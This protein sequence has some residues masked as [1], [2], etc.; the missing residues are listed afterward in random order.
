MS[1]NRKT[2]DGYENLLMT[3]VGE[4]GIQGPAGPKGDKGDIG[5]KWYAGVELEEYS[6][7]IVESNDMKAG[8]YYLN[9]NS[10]NVLLIT[11]YHDSD[12]VGGNAFE[13]SVEKVG[14]IHGRNGSKIY[15]VNTLSD[16]GTLTDVK[17][18]D[19]LVT[20][21]TFNYYT[22]VVMTTPEGGTEV[23]WSKQGCLKPDAD[24]D[25]SNL[26]FYPNEF[27]EISRTASGGDL[28]LNFPV[29]PNTTYVFETGKSWTGV[30]PTGQSEIGHGPSTTEVEFTTGA[31]DTTASGRFY[32][33]HQI[34]DVN[35]E[36]ASFVKLY[37]KDG[38]SLEEYLQMI[39][40]SSGG[41]SAT[42]GLLSPDITE[43]LLTASNKHP[44]EIVLMGDS[45]TEG[46]SASGM[47]SAGSS[48]T[49]PTWANYGSWAGLLNKFIKQNYPNVTVRNVGYSG[50]TSSYGS[51]NVNTWITNNRQIAIVM[52][53]TNNR[54]SAANMNALANDYTTIKN[55]CDAV[56]ARMV[57]MCCI[58]A[59]PYNEAISGKYVATM[60]DVHTVLSNWALSNGYELVDLYAMMSRYVDFDLS[61][62]ETMGL[63][64]VGSNDNNLHLHPSDA[65]HAI[66]FEFIKY[67]LGLSAPSGGSSSSG[68]GSGTG[69]Y[70]HRL[71][72]FTMSGSTS[73]VNVT[74]YNNRSTPYN[75]SAITT[76]DEINTVRNDIIAAGYTGY[77]Q[78]GT[79]LCSGNIGSTQVC[80][81]YV[82]GGK[83]NFIGG[84][85][86]TVNFPVETGGTSSATQ[87][88]R[89]WDTVEPAGGSGGSSGGE[90]T[91]ISVDEYLDARSMNAIA[92]SPV[93][94]A[95]A[96]LDNDMISLEGRVK[97]LEKITENP[98]LVSTTYTLDG[99]RL[100]DGGI[101]GNTYRMATDY[102]PVEAG[103]TIEFEF[104]E[105][106]GW[107]ISGCAY[108]LSQGFVTAIFNPDGWTNNYGPW[109][110]E[111]TGY[112]RVAFRLNGYEGV[113]LNT[114]E[115]PSHIRIY[116]N[117]KGNG[118]S[119]G[120]ST[121]IVVDQVLDQGSSNAISNGAVTTALTNLEVR[122][123]AVESVMQQ[124]LTPR[125]Y[126]FPAA[127]GFS[128]FT[129]ASV[130]WK[131][132]DNMVHITCNVNITTQFN[133][134]A[135]LGTMPEGYRPSS[136]VTLPCTFAYESN[137]N[138]I[139]GGVN[140]N[141]DGT[142]RYYGASVDGSSQ[143]KHLIINAEYAVPPVATQNEE[144]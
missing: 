44:V 22:A 15:T 47:E 87:S 135:L 126:S 18:G 29:K 72:F 119:G 10:G 143:T 74:F 103:D 73:Y 88:L 25:I 96:E 49:V 134:N 144:E 59:T 105:D 79:L 97:V 2:A 124:F 77:T 109:D 11:D 40:G 94:L 101:Y 55:R 42:A 24:I 1:L 129:S 51:A 141:T 41:G 67:K 19:V 99:L 121:S 66:M 9:T 91:S 45:I 78:I 32:T 62:L 80:G 64:Y 111:G 137:F 114:D 93:A 68:G 118:S 85:N 86:F 136:T 12:R 95:I 116:K 13:Y 108:N 120:G 131:T 133:P 82:S 138:P 63:I 26:R 56:G 6:A 33:G 4:Q 102:I 92:N 122:M 65:G 81:M 61:N 36:D 130:Y 17:E 8:D 43:Y 14:N 100:Q 140:V 70:R 83:F 21:D 115:Y 128:N 106:S 31:T 52:Y 30:T 46:Y 23:N 71:T 27:E 28:I 7:N 98:H 125:K 20:T 112:I 90:S 48:H 5:N 57:P 123:N 39:A 58:P 76:T 69:S 38:V 60:S 75:E 113:Q 3:H 139:A 50:Q 132:P 84:G 110:I 142:I 107:E 127:S 104:D 89:I 117:G 37:R 34:T 53:G 54:T 16:I 35:S